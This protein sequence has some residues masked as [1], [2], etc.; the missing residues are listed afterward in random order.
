MRTLVAIPVYNEERYVCSVIRRVVEHG[1][2]VLVIDDGSTDSTARR[3]EC[4]PV[5]VVRH[6]TNL[7]YGRS[8]PWGTALLWSCSLQASLLGSCRC[9]FTDGGPGNVQLQ[10]VHQ[11]VD[12]GVLCRHALNGNLGA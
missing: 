1:H 2:D 11:Q 7:G 9:Q 6:A 5:R 3:L 8:L 12:L 4:M 10:Q